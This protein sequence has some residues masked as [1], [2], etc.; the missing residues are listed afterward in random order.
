MIVPRRRSG[1]S[2]LSRFAVPPWNQTSEDWLKIDR[3]LGDDHL[4]RVIERGVALLDLTEL[5]ESYSGHGTKPHRPDL[6]L[7]MALFCIQR[8]HCSPAQWFLE[9]LENKAVQ[10]LG[11]GLRPSRSV[12]FEFAARIHRHLDS[13]N[14]QVVSAAQASGHT[15]ATRGSL[16]GTCVEAHASRHRLLNQGQLLRRQELLNAAI[17]GDQQGVPLAAQPGWMAKTPLTRLRQQAQYELAQHKLEEHLAENRQRLPSQRQEEK[18]IRISAVDPEAALGKDKHKVFRPLYNVQYLRDL[19]SPYLL[20]YG[21]FARS[22]DAGTLVPMLERTRQLTG[23]LPDVVLGDSGYIT[24]LDLADAQRLGVDLYGPWK[25]NDYSSQKPAAELIS[26]DQ[27]LWDADRREYRCPQGHPLT[28]RSS[29]NRKCSLGRTQ[30][31]F[32]YEADAATCATCPLKARCCP[33][34]QSG[35]H[36]NRSEHAELIE[37]HR[38]KMET[39][40]A[41]ACYK[42]RGQTVETSFGDSKQHRNFRRV[43]GRGLWRAKMQAAIIVLAHNLKQFVQ[44][45]FAPEPPL[46]ET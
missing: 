12:W 3:E 5:F 6:M 27:F 21:V 2:A 8:G 14:Q 40:E 17:Q 25:E 4:V 46:D 45:E 30:K 7:G 34:S 37:A 23:H 33:K 43:N 9:A 22:S 31:I 13:W 16:D 15:S 18:H 44:F 11:F 38:R 10:W 39:P 24:A 36:V 35:R 41:K 20:A 29:Q 32:L 19:D 42:L 28:L 26:K 1:K